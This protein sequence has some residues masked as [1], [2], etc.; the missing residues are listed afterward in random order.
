MELRPPQSARINV[1]VVGSTGPSPSRPHPPRGRTRARGRLQ[2]QRGTAVP[3]APPRFRRRSIPSL[4]STLRVASLVLI[5]GA[6]PCRSLDELDPMR[7][8]HHPG[9]VYRNPSPSRCHNTGCVATHS[10]RL[11]FCKSFIFPYSKFYNK[12]NVHNMYNEN[13][14]QIIGNNRKIRGEIIANEGVPQFLKLT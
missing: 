4:P 1:R 12:C 2:R 6:E 7:G 5:P 3:P 14:T 11:D 10:H 9:H 13:M 8:H